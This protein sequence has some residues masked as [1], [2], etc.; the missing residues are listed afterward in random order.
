MGVG[1]WG[2]AEAALTSL[3]PALGCR[4]D[5]GGALG[6]GCEPRTGA[7]RCR[8]NTQGATCNEWVPPLRLGWGAGAG[9][10]IP[11]GIL[12]GCAGPVL[13]CPDRVAGCP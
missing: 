5:I 13:P 3:P 11:L 10:G 12:G 6:Q 2:G 4:C 1:A 8:P 7:C 9:G